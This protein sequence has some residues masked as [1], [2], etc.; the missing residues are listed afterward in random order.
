MERPSTPSRSSGVAASGMALQGGAVAAP[1]RPMTPGSGGMAAVGGMPPPTAGGAIGGVVAAPAVSA[2]PAGLAS[3]ASRAGRPMSRGAGMVLPRP[4][5]GSALAA[6]AARPMTGTGGG[7]LG[8]IG[9]GGGGGAGPGRQVHDRSF[10]LDELHRQKHDLAHEIDALKVSHEELSEDAGKAAALQRR[11]TELRARVRELKGALTDYNIVLDK[12]RTA[13]GLEQLR[14]AG[15]VANEK[16]AT[17]R[18]EADAAYRQRAAKD[19]VLVELEEQLLAHMQRQEARLTELAPA[20]REQ[21]AALQE[22]NRG[23]LASVAKAEGEEATLKRRCAEL[24]RE[25]RA[26]D[27][28]QRLLSLREQLRT[29]EDKARELAAEEAKANMSPEERKEALMAQMKK[30]NA[31]IAGAEEEIKAADR[32]V[33]ALRQQLA[34]AKTDL[35]SARAD[36]QSDKLEQLKRKDREM[37]AFMDAF[38]QQR[39]EVAAANA[40][41][42]QNILAALQRGSAKLQMAKELPNAG[43]FKQLQEEVEFKKSQLHNATT[44]QD[45]LDDELALRKGELQKIGA[46]D[47]KISKE[48]GSLKTKLATMREEIEVY[49]RCGRA[50]SVLKARLRL[51]LCPRPRPC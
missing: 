4:G 48:L 23:L 44:T 27:G 15:K 45:R 11:E 25:L 36:D 30:D 24:E 2:A 29:V 12:H 40:S 35:N 31:D 7:A 34:S 42:R 46:L 9:G 10:F 47:E 43:R 1:P 38:P 20:M 3:K 18:R 19:Q 16:L 22:E 37:E 21:Y 17:T 26:D 13:N 6:A 32:E 41:V 28:K 14:E 5:T 33:K 49:G 50:Q 51:C 8:G 39:D